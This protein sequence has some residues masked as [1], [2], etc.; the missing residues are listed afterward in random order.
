MSSHPSITEDWSRKGLM[1]V[2]WLKILL[3]AY[4]CSLERRCHL[5]D[6][7][8]LRGLITLRL[9]YSSTSINI[10]SFEI[11]FDY[12]SNIPC[13]KPAPPRHSEAYSMDESAP[14]PNLRDSFER[15]TSS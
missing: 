6:R 4:C 3:L 5:L 14:L 13:L 11:D 2:L 9:R 1:L 12:L 10:P 8:K 15:N 7:S